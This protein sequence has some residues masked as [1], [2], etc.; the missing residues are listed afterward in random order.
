MF[1][2][3]ERCSVCNPAKIFFTSKFSYLLFCN[4]TH[5]TETGTANR[6]GG[7]LLI[8]NQ[9]DQSLQWAD[10]KHFWSAVWSERCCATMYQPPQ[11]M[12]L[13]WAKTIFLS[14]TGVFWLFL[15]QQFYH[16]GSRTEHHWRCSFLRFHLV[17]GW[18]PN[19]RYHIVNPRS[20]KRQIFL[21]PLI[22]VPSSISSIHPFIHRPS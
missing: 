15:T 11:T 7:G 21:K 12:Q 8:A 9:L 13:C 18:W 16:A 20:T 1:D 17:R 10:Q 5:K 6:W 3:L 22:C 14:Q 4:F 2:H 19:T